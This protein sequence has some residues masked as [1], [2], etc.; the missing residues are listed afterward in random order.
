MS[1]TTKTK[2]NVIEIKHWIN[3]KVLYSDET[4]ESLK[5]AVTRAIANRTH[6]RGAYLRGAY[7]RGADLRGAYLEGADLEGADLEGADLEGADLE[8][9]KGLDANNRPIPLTAEEYQQRAVEYRQKH[10]E[11]PVVP[12]LDSTICNIVNTGQGKLQM[13]NWHTCDTE[14]CRAGWAIHLAGDKGYDLEAKF[15]SRMAGGMIYRAST[16]R[17]PDFFANNEE[18]LKD[19]CEWGAKEAAA[20]AVAL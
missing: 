8:G 13:S 1:T 6:L 2:N 10:P 4:A 7:L 5:D 17:Y 14:H 9:A 15:G 3:N 19:I 18:A 12:A 20:P 11:I 16:G